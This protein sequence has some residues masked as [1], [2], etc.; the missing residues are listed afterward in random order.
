MELMLRVY[1][2][3]TTTGNFAW[4]PGVDFDPVVTDDVPS[5]MDAEDYEDSNGLPHFQPV[6]NN[7]HTVEGCDASMEQ[8]PTGRPTKQKFGGSIQGQQKKGQGEGASKLASSMENLASS[9]K[10]Q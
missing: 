3:A 8:T 9:V 4:T 10:S 7:E 1:K 5:F 2:G 6:A